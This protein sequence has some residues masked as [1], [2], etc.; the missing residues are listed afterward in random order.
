[1]K[2]LDA[3]LDNVDSL[4]D[5]NENLKLLISKLKNDCKSFDMKEAELMAEIE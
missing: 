4:K 1:M 5:E 2:N 3:K